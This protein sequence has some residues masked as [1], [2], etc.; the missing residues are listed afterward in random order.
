MHIIL[1]SNRLATAKTVVVTPRRLLAAALAFVAVVLG[2]SFLFSYAS[3]AFRLPFVQELVLAAQQSETQKTQVF[4]R[5]NLNAMASRLGELQAQLL[6][7][8]ALGERITSLAGIKGGE[9]P[10]AGAKPGQ[11]GPFVAPAA[12]QGLSEATL[13]RELDRLAELVDAQS[14]NLTVL[15]SRL[16]DQRIRSNLLPTIVPIRDAHIGSTFGIRSDPLLGI[17]AMHE[18]IDF[19]APPGTEVV[20]AA[21]GIVVLAEMHPQYGNLIEIDHSNGFSTR[22]AHL[23]R[24]LVKPGQIVKRG[25]KIAESGNTGR[26]TGPHLHFEVRYNG[27]AQNPARFLQ[28]NAQAG[29]PQRA[30]AP[31][32]FASR[33]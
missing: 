10:A 14:D 22:Y 31:A 12:G 1:V 23:S 16:M 15:E 8:D 11:G 33:R 32:S 27:V 29:L 9:R 6:R 17:S 4:V 3:V 28:Q 7:L 5:D 20:S 30:A 2:L 25:R 13:Q 21:G 18:G 19:V 26:S 24:L